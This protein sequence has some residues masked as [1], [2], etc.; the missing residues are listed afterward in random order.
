MHNVST[1]HQ[2][3]QTIAV[4]IHTILPSRHLTAYQSRPL[5][6]TIIFSRRSHKEDNCFEYIFC[7]DEIG[8]LI[9]VLYGRK[10]AAKPDD[11]NAS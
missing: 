9:W 5:K 1:Y 2:R 10:N 6:N 11:A 8:M 3:F 4:I 7:I